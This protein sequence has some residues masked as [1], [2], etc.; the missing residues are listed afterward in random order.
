MLMR[1]LRLLRIL[2]LVKLV[3]AVEPLSKQEIREMFAAIGYV[4][5][6][7]DFAEVWRSA[8]GDSTRCSVQGF[9]MSLNEH[10]D[11]ARA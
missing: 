11:N 10:L 7:G 5:A 2:R 3:K 4:L 8:C 6:D 1:M 9:Q